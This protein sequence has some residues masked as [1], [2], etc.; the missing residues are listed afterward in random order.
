MKVYI[1]SFDEKGFGYNKEK[2]IHV[3]FAYPGDLVEVKVWKR[4]KKF[5]VG[6]IKEI[7]EESPYRRKDKYCK[8]LGKCGGCLWGLMDYKFQ[9]IFKENKV[10]N[11]FD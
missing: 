3:P 4:K 1:D 7:I 11:L 6:E 5:K 10:K 9:L 2:N 8:H